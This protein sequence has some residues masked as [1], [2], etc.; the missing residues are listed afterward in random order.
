MMEKTETNTVKLKS[1][2]GRYLLSVVV[3]NG[4][5]IDGSIRSRPDPNISVAGGVLAG[6]IVS[7]AQEIDDIVAIFTEMAAEIGK[8]VNE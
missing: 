8:Y 7:S 4:K 3:E 5:I 2:A 6:K 1:F